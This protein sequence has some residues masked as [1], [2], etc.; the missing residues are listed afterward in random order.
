MPT[1]VTKPT[2]PF[3]GRWRIV[4]MEQWDRD[5]ID[6]EGPGFITFSKGGN[7]EFHFGAVHGQLDCRVEN[8][9]DGQHI[10]FSWEGNDEMD[11]V[12]GRGWAVLKN[13]ELHGRLYF[14][15]GDDSSFRAVGR[16]R[17]NRTVETDAP[18]A[19]RRSR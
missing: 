10:E 7:G 15:H 6:L 2:N 1:R 18:Q 13:G 4:E 17:S 14:H 5:F 8:F 9:A 11:P 12:I 3:L 16:S 19:A